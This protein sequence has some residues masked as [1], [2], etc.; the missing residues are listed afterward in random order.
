MNSVARL[1]P[2]MVIFL[3]GFTTA[4]VYDNLA[5]A[6]FQQPLTSAMGYAPERQSPGDHI[7]EER[8]HVYDDRI[9][10]DIQ[11][12]SWST[13]SDTNSMD[14]FIDRGANGIELHPG[15]PENVDVGDVISFD[16]SFAQGIVIHRV[17]STGEDENGWYA[18]TKGDNNPSADP[19]KRRFKD[20]HG[21]L[22]GVL[23]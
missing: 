10:I 13:F 3:L 15:R 11:D 6:G 7:P 23:Y 8:I 1:I 12:A 16:A 21:V 17:I 18:I 4:H 20:I 19:G 2:F 9:I 5:A 22:V 14:P